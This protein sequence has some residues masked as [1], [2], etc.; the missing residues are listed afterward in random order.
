MRTRAARH[1]PLKFAARFSRKAVIPLRP[2]RADACGR[3]Q[4]ADF[5][6]SLNVRHFAKKLVSDRCKVTDLVD[7]FNKHDLATLVPRTQTANV[8]RTEPA[9]LC[10]SESAQGSA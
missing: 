8:A 9:G 10:G 3:N 2:C 7:V 1:R 5:S 6:C 4:C